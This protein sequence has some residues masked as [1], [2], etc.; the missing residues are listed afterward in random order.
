MKPICYIV[1]AGDFS[2]ACFPLNYRDDDLLLAADG[3]YGWLKKHNLK[4]DFIIGDLDS[5]KELPLD[6][7]ILRFPQQKDDT[8]MMLAVK[9]GQSLGYNT[10]V[11]YG[12]TGGRLD[13]TI[14]NLQL[15][16][17]IANHN[18]TGYL[19]DAVSLMTVIKNKSI[20]IKGNPNA[21]LSVFSLTPKS[22]GVTLKGVGYPLSDGILTSDFPLGVSNYL[23]S[24]TATISVKDGVLLIHLSGYCIDNI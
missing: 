1:G 13:H 23:T 20:S 10:F 2:E 3:G 21:G 15:L 24:D 16:H 4:P 18:G 6:T 5:I 12:A 9:H 19:A 14:A 17:Y 11:I 8:D 7:P 22:E